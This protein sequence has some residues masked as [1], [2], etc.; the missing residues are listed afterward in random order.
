MSATSD[1]HIGQSDAPL[2]A[3]SES[4]FDGVADP[5][6]D[7]IILTWN[8]GALLRRATESALAS[9]G[10]RVHVVVV[11]NGSNAAL[12]LPVDERID[13]LRN[14]INRGVATGRNQGVRAGR[15]PYVCILDSDARLE[16][17]SLRRLVDGLT[18]DVGLTGPVFVGQSPAASGGR[19]PTFTTKVRR[20]LN[21]TS[22]Y[23]AADRPA[24]P[25]DRASGDVDFVIGACQVM[26]RSVFETVGGID[27]TYFY[28]PEDVDFCL[29]IR[30]AGWRIRQLDAPVHHPPRRRNKNLITRR[31]VNHAK[32]VARHLW[33]HRR[34]RQRIAVADAERAAARTLPALDP[35]SAIDVQVVLYGDAPLPQI[36]ARLAAAPRPV[37]L[38]VVDHSPTPGHISSPSMT[39]VADPGNPGFGAGQNRAALL[40]DAP[41]IL[42][43]NPDAVIDWKAVEDGVVALCSD[44]RRVA[45]QGRITTA[46]T[47]AVERA[48]GREL[49]PLDLWGR[50]LGARR[51]LDIPAAVAIARRLGVMAHQTQRSAEIDRPVETLAATAVLIRRDAFEAVGGFCDDYFLYGEDLDLCRRLRARGWLLWELA[52][53]WALHENGASAGAD[54]WAERERHWW[55]GTMQFCV[56]WWSTPSTLAAIGAST[57][58]AARI[59]RAGGS[60]VI[61]PLVTEPL[62][63]A[64]DTARRRRVARRTVEWPIC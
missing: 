54:G 11:D 42:L 63:D 30:A 39:V 34:T 45:V 59:S 16:P 12:D 32:A 37:R 49:G 36:A 44:A 5:E 19:A 50:A 24:A 13:V 31:G 25:A 1:P 6:V 33:R 14:P 3:A 2:V 46:S 15:A 28:G 21:L 17:Q 55:T 27:E 26:R 20:A 18:P 9:E 60:S 8:D 47:G 29:R 53:P 52:R 22:E 41:L 62:R 61:R 35:S 56:R 10:V 40:G 58:M 38:I 4:S 43:L 64:A 48:G 51:L 23:E 7:I 57:V